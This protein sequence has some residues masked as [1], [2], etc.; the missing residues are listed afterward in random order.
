VHFTNLPESGACTIRVFD[1]AG[2]PVKTLE[3]VNGTT[4]EIWNLKN[5]SNIPV[6]SGMYIVIVETDAGDKILKIAI[7]QPEQRLDLYG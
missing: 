6:A 1:L 4:L 3:H 5:D 2:V 7:I